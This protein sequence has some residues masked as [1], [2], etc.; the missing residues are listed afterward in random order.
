MHTI[1]ID[2]HI[3]AIDH[4]VFGF[5]GAG[6]SYVVRGESVALI[7][8]GT[9]LTVPATLAGLEK[10]GIAREAVEHIICTHVHMDHA[11]GAGYLARDLPRAVVYIHS[12]T[13]QHLV[14]PSR[15]MPSV[16]RAVGE[17]T[18]PLHGDVL[19]LDPDRMRPAEEL[20][21]DLGRDVILDALP[22]PGH[23]PDHVAFWDRRTG[24]MFIGDGTSLAMPRFQMDLPVAPPPAYNLEQHLATTAMLRTQDISRF[25]VTHTGV[26]EDVN[27][28]LNVT[29]EKLHELDAI[30][31]EHLDKGDED[32]PAMAARWHIYDGDDPDGKLLERNLSK[33]SVAGVLRYEKK[34]REAAAS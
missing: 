15:L 25:Y 23:S 20:H 27:Y 32:I 21:L 18:W 16:R 9:S 7:E 6:V 10:L 31:R 34:R 4:E 19:P 3:S 29:E 8:T 11:G 30:V 2:D 17:E 12:M 22:T 13:G 24:G 28:L 5:E 26:C 14:D 33:M 1:T